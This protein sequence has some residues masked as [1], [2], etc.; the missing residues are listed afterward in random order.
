MHKAHG[1]T[2]DSTFI[3]HRK[4][5][6]LAPAVVTNTSELTTEERADLAAALRKGEVDSPLNFRERFE[7]AA[8]LDQGD[9]SR[10][11]E[12]CAKASERADRPNRVDIWK[13]QAKRVDA[14]NDAF[15][16]MRQARSALRKAFPSADGHDI[17]ELLVGL[18][19]EDLDGPT[20]NERFLEG[21]L[22]TGE[23]S[24]VIA[25]ATGRLRASLRVALKRLRDR[26]RDDTRYTTRNGQS[27][28]TEGV[29]RSVTATGVGGIKESSTDAETATDTARLH[30][31]GAPDGNQEGHAR[32]DGE[33][34][35]DSA[36][37]ARAQAR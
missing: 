18:T 19:E 28:P 1:P 3:G 29:T 22:A 4:A 15:V 32:C 16:A 31:S 13:R 7:V 5:A 10:V 30:R 35:L 6:P 8:A 23:L 11:D 26:K 25:Q 20:P 27:V 14:V 24:D 37:P 12:I 34:Q 21:A 36:R 17:R 33:P 9:V 2:I